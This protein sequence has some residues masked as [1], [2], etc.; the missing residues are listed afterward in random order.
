MI[1]RKLEVGQV[2][3]SID[4]STYEIIKLYKDYYDSDHVAYIQYSSGSIEASS[5][6]LDYFCGLFNNEKIITN[7]D[8]T[9]YKKL[10]DYRVGDVWED[11]GLNEAVLI[12]R[13]F[14]PSELGYVEF[15]GDGHLVHDTDLTVFPENY[16]LI[17]RKGEGVKHYEK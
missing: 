11:I 16:R 10:N 17:Y 6:I 15:S 9:P 1:K 4:S 8:G 12:T 7:A 13:G 2:W 5:L 14:D 3:Q